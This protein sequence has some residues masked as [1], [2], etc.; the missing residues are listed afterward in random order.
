[1]PFR[2]SLLSLVF[3]FSAQGFAST[4]EEISVPPQVLNGLKSFEPSAV[5][6]L[7]DQDMFLIASDDTTKDDK[8]LLFL[9]NRAGQVSPSVIALD[10]IEKM[11]D[12]ESLSQD[13]SGMIYAMSSQGL[14][15]SGQEKIE[16]NLFVRG[17][18]KNGEFKVDRYIY[19]RPLLLEALRQSNIAELQALSSN[20]TKKLDIESHLIKDRHLYIGL[21]DPQAGVGKALMLNIGPIDEIFF[22]KKLTIS[23]VTTF[24]FRSISGE[25]DLLSDMS[26]QED[27]VFLTT[28]QES[29]AGRV[30]SYDLTTNN[31]QLL[32]EFEELRPEGLT[33]DK[34]HGHFMIVFDQS[35]EPALF[36]SGPH[37]SKL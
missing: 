6:Y 3:F 20:F 33:F 35:N 18:L 12:I 29:G 31:L 23:G 37:L 26:L 22:Q 17:Y 15:K 4:P 27:K 11:A 8:P 10:T 28:T 19:L 36:L 34:A 16:R 2:L 7:A 25:T 5:L 13:E 21:K 24:N 14:N 30:W 9:M 32:N 1:M